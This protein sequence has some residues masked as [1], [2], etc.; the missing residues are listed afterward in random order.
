[1]DYVSTFDM[2]KIGIGPSS[3]HT[4]GPWKAGLQFIEQYKGIHSIEDIISIEV[5]LYGSLAL[6]GVGHGTDFAV[7][8]GLSGY[9]P[10]TVPLERVKLVPQQI[11]NTGF[12][13]FNQEKRVHFDYNNDI[14]FHYDET[15]SYHPNG[16]TIRVRSEN[17][18]FEREYY[19]IGGGFIVS[20]PDQNPPIPSETMN[21]VPYPFTT[22]DEL[23]VHCI[24]QDRNIYSIAMANELALRSEM[25]VQD[26][27]Y[28]I[29]AEMLQSI[30]RGCHTRGH[31]PGG[32]EVRRRASEL[33]IKLGGED[34]KYTEVYS[35]L[36]ELRN[37]EVEFTKTVKWISCF[38]LAVNEENAAYGRI[39]TAPTNGAAGVIPAVLLYGVSFANKEAS[40]EDIYN[41]LLTAS[42][43]GAIFKHGSTISAAMGGCQ[44]EIGVS[45]AMA[46]AALTEFLGGSAEQAMVAAEIAMEHHLGLT[47]DPV[48]GL[49]QIPCIERNSMGAMKAITATHMALET[50]PEETKVSLDSVVKTMWETAQDMSTKYKET[51]LGGLATNIAV[52]VPEC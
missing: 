52:N 28:L 7:V 20:D 34:L 21:P 15:L 35:W 50:N 42:S 30:Y 2:L 18:I 32:L 23:K 31:L 14:H 6:T 40:L 4:L 3:S 16:M 39:V 33:Y 48:K 25:D 45:S 29:W 27:L 1:M 36:K 43:I 44:A 11:R 41:F 22:A 13:H 26:S 9:L 47:C 12:I 5:H 37:L 49:V 24:A 51:S 10:A 8:M 38:A 19:S 17:F 46:A